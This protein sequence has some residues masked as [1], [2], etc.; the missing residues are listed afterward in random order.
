MKV[1][2]QCHKLVNEIT[3]IFNSLIPVVAVPFRR[4]KKISENDCVYN[5][6]KSVLKEFSFEFLN[7]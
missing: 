5:G 3:L 1:Q 6:N 7:P 2:V 4:V